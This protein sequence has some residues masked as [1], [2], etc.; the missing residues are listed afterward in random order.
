MKKKKG[1]GKFKT[2]C[3]TTNTLFGHIIILYKNGCILSE[4][5][6]SKIL[7]MI[8]N[9]IMF[10]T[11]LYSSF[12]CFAMKLTRSETTNHSRSGTVINSQLRSYP[13]TNFQN[14]GLEVMSLQSYS[15]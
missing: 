12:G 4:L 14:R 9:H 3:Y 1:I 6:T 5:S 15:Q 2:L 11:L 8:F 10:A 7:G 13:A